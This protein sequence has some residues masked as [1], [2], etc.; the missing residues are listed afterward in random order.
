MTL[1]KLILSFTAIVFIFAGC[2]SKVDVKKGDRLVVLETL[3]ESAETQWEDSYTDGFTTEIPV[4]TVMEVLFNPRTGSNIIE[5]KPIEVNGTKDAQEVDNF[6]VPEHIR[7]KQG[8]VGYSFSIK[9]EYMGK[10]VKK[11]E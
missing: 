8:Y 9:T 3:R 2:S 1:S 4:G 5:C 6:F 11:A 7:N 10:K